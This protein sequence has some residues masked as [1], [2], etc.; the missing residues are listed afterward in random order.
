MAV[1]NQYK[2]VGVDDSTSGSALTPFGSG[3]PLVS[4][5]YV[6]KSI[7]VTSAGTPTVTVTNNSIT[8]IKSAALTANTT[9]ELLTQPLIVEGGKTFTIQ[10][11]SSDSFDVAISYLNIKKETVS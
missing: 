8:T 11:S 3:N 2:F 5:T 10:S 6:I 4:E 7:L 9:T 1:V